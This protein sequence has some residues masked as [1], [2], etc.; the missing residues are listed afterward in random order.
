MDGDGFVDLLY[1]YKG[2]AGAVTQLYRN[3]ANADGTR[4]WSNAATNGQFAGLIPPT[5]FPFAADKVGD[6]GVR[7]ADVKGDGHPYMLVGFLPAGAGAVPTLAAFSNDGTKWVSA[8]AYAPPVPFVAQI[9]TTTDPSRDLAVQIV[10]VN[11]DGLPDIVAKYHDPTNPSALVEGVWLNSGSGWVKDVSISVPVSLDTLRWDPNQGLQWEKNASIQWTDVNGDGLQDIV[12][13]RREG[14]NNESVTYLGTGKGWV[15][16]TNWQIPVDA[17]ADRGGDPGLRLIDVNG[18]GYADLLYIRQDPDGSTKK[19]LFVNSGAGWLA[20]DSSSV[21]DLPFVDKD[22]NDLGIRLFDVDGRGLVDIVRSYTGDTLQTSIKINQGR[23]SDVVSAID[24]GYGLVTRMFYQSLLEPDLADIGS[25]EPPLRPELA[26]QRIYEPV[27]SPT[28][29]PILAP[30]PASYNVRRVIVSDG[31]K[32]NN[33]FSYRYG[34]YRVDALSKAS[35]GFAWRESVNETTGV[36]TH[37]D[38]SQDLTVIG[39]VLH[40]QTCYLDFPVKSS[41]LPIDSQLCS[42]PPVKGFEWVHPLTKVDNV[43][44]VEEAQVGGGALASRTFRQVTLKQATSYSYELDGQNTEWHTDSFTYDEQPAPHTL[45]ER[46]ANLLTSTT[47]RGDGS[48]VTTTNSYD[49]DDSAR[50]FLGRLTKSIVTK[51]PAHT[52]TGKQIAPEVKSVGFTYN[53]VTGLLESET[54]NFGSSRQVTISYI[55][56]NYGNVVQKQRHASG[57]PDTG[58]TVYTFDSVH[59]ALV[60]TTNPL[61]QKSTQSVS[62]TSGLPTTTTD[63]N[64][65]TTTYTYDAFGRSFRL[66]TPTGLDTVLTATSEYV[67]LGELGPG[68]PITGVPAAY[69]LRLQTNDG[70]HSLPATVQLLDAKGRVVRTISQGF[71]KNAKATRL[72]LQDKIYDLLGRPFQTS[73]P[74][75]PGQKPLWN[76]TNRDVLSRVTEQVAANGGTIRIAYQGKKGGGQVTTVTDSRPRKATRLVTITN[77]HGLPTQVIDDAGGKVV[78]EYDADDRPT[79]ITDPI[80]SITSYSYD[81]FGNRKSISDPNFGKWNY[82]Y[83]SLGRLVRQLDGSAGGAQVARLEY[84][85]LGR[86]KTKSSPSEV[87]TW[88]Y[89]DADHGIGKLAL[90]QNDSGKY[91]ERYSYDE[92]SRTSEVNVTVESTTFT[93]SKT[94]DS[95]GRVA[96]ITYPDQFLV[97]N[98]Y[99]Q[100]GFLSAISDGTTH[101]AYWSLDATD[102]FGNARK[103]T[104]GNGVVETATYEPKTGRPSELQAVDDSGKKIMDLTLQYDLAGDLRVRAESVQGRSESFEY[105]NLDRLASMSREDG[106]IDRYSYDL[107]GRFKTRAD[108]VYAYANGTQRKIPGC[109]QGTAAAH[110]VFSSKDVQGVRSYGYDCHGNMTSSGDEAYSYSSENQLIKA[111]RLGVPNLRSSE[112][113]SYGPTGRRFQER[114]RHGLRVLETISIGGYEKITEF[115]TGNQSSTASF[116]RR[117]WYLSNGSGTFAVVEKSYQA[118][119]GLAGTVFH[120]GAVPVGDTPVATSAI[121][122]LHKDQQGS[123]LAISDGSGGVRA[124]YWYDPWGA[125]TAQ[126]FDRTGIPS[127][128]RLEDS[129]SR[130]FIGQEHLQDFTLIHLNGRLYDTRLAMF[131]SVDPVNQAPLDGQLWNPYS[132]SRNN[133]LR[134]SDPNGYCFLVCDIGNAISSVGNAIGNAVSSIGQGIG[135]AFDQAGKWVGQNWR[136]IVVVAAVVVVTVVTAGAA[137]PEA[138]TLGTAILSGMAAGAT[139][140]GLSAA[141]YGGNVNDVLTGAIKGGVIGAFSG[142]AFY[143]VGT[144]TA[145]SGALNGV[146]GVAGHGLVGGAQEAANGGNFWQGFEAGSLTKASSLIVPSFDS[147]ALNTTRAAIVGG[148]VAVIGGGNFANGAVTGAFSY[149][150]NDQLHPVREENPYSLDD[151]FSSKPQV[152]IGSSVGIGPKAYDVFGDTQYGFSTSCCGVGPGVGTDSI[153]GHDMFSPNY[154]VSCPF[155]LCSVGI[156][157][158]YNNYEIGVGG[159]V[160]ILSVEGAYS[161]SVNLPRL[162][163]RIESSIY[164]WMGV[165]HY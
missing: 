78:Y 9:G 159:S 82:E 51:V 119:D 107:G 102:S 22:G 58:P 31:P 103:A 46:R 81:E 44:D 80:G 76:T 79:K 138:A 142:A 114:A 59:R 111:E 12:Y 8:P 63:P 122:Y 86:L 14:N 48:Q 47:S 112:E 115:G 140:G 89:D 25:G 71:S 135:Q 35:L 49:A 26:W 156:S 91:K 16:S 127:G 23:R 7:F 56:D 139:A 144:L 101:K 75:E 158:S 21:P 116:V 163:Q 68:V 98:T 146:E 42:K 117:R 160:R 62:P 131:T 113:F 118:F 67:E 133:P 54:S 11:G 134:Y 109:S 108:T 2:A 96:R 18:D 64:G 72:I 106:S 28:S 53:P 110:A 45:L 33:A 57:V 148:G 1:S 29:Y 15:A 24:A 95:F 13:I 121:W 147:S 155:Q 124:R 154:G 61:G 145:G 87:W 38:L 55:R 141:L 165:P 97:E 52:G 153:V 83:D 157:G 50:W 126:V 74:Y 152:N 99:D 143:G 32:R 100:N 84:D 3:V 4:M 136:Q 37:T 149:A 36:L 162:Y 66:E 88:Q 77:M 129:W 60:A 5:A 65:I 123:I 19:G 85:A 6:M 90:I 20:K 93:T 137:G 39:R 161:N 10:D 43:W 151:A 41:G 40:E 27:S 150:L 164:Q 73:L 130:G 17:V 34:S 69:G 92:V 128:E 30:I 94:F 104:L 125:R 120:D 105:D 132:Y 70:V